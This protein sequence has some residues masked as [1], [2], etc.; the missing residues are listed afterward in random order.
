IGEFL[1]LPGQ[2]FSYLYG[3]KIKDEF[4]DEISGIPAH[5]DLF[6]ELAK[7]FESLN[8]TDFSL[9]P[10]LKYL[11]LDVIRNFDQTVNWYRSQEEDFGLA[12][13]ILRQSHFAKSIQIN[14]SVYQNSGANHVQQIAFAIAHGVEYLEKFGVEAGEK[15]YF[16]TAVGGNYFFEIAKLRA[17]RKFWNLI[18]EEYGSEAETFIYVENSLRN[19]SLLDMQNNLIR[20]GLETAAAV[21]GKADAVNV[22]PYDSLQNP[23][24]FSEELASKQQ[25]LLKKESFF[26][27][28]EDPAAGAYFVE[29]LTELMA[30]SALELFKKTESEGGFLKG[31]FEGSVQKMV[32][33]SAEK[34]QQAF[35]EGKIVLIGVNKFRNPKDKLNI[36]TNEKPAYRT[37]IQPISA[38]R[39]SEKI[40]L[41]L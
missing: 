12:G 31:L 13:E 29:N 3:L 5:L 22:L 8:R 28:F 18:L 15:I 32:Q 34:E 36:G 35:D 37:Q 21:Q 30:R 14:A 40:E 9:I 33:K 4:L 23:T 27:R 24:A 25:L 41:N 10:N 20:S 16:K 1:N 17:L 39:L 26:D 11:Y 6:L 2:D 19:K 38:K 7:P